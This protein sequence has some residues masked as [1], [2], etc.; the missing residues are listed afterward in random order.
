MLVN[1]NNSRQDPHPVFAVPPMTGC[2]FGSRTVIYGPNGTGKTTLVRELQ[3]HSEHDVAQLGPQWDTRQSSLFVFNERFVKDNLLQF[4]EEGKA[5]ASI[6]IGKASVKNKKRKN[7]IFEEQRELNAQRKQRT[8][9]VEQND[10]VAVETAAK[11]EVIERL[12]KYDSK[13]YQSA[14]YKRG[15]KFREKL[16]L[17]TKASLTDVEYADCVNVAQAPSLGQIV[18]IPKFPK[19][20]PANERLDSIN[21]LLKVQLGDPTEIKFSDLEGFGYW[22]EAGIKFSEKTGGLCPFCAQG[23]DFGRLESMVQAYVNDR[24]TNL[25][26]ELK[27]HQEWMARYVDQIAEYGK[28]L[29]QLPVYDLDVIQEIKSINE[30]L[31][32]ELS[33]LSSSIY[34]VIDAIECKIADLDKVSHLRVVALPSEVNSPMTD[35]DECIS[36]YNQAVEGLA[37]SRAEAVRKLEGSILS[38]FSK[39]YTAA[40]SKSQ[41]LNLEIDRID[42]RLEDLETELAS[43]LASESSTLD[44]ALEINRGI[45]TIFGRNEFEIHPSSDGQEYLL[46]RSDGPATHLS[47]GEK[48]VVCLLY[49]LAS[50]NAD[51]VDLSDSVILIDD[52]VTGLDRNNHRAL[53]DYVVS[54]SDQWQQLII[55]THD[56]GL[57]SNF[58]N[59]FGLESKTQ[60]YG[61]P[62]G[63]ILERSW[64]EDV[65]RYLTSICLAPDYLVHNSSEYFYLFDLCVRAALG[66]IPERSLGVIGNSGRRFLESFASYHLPRN[67]NFTDSIFRMWDRVDWER[68]IGR[69]KKL[70]LPNDQISSSTRHIAST[71]IRKFHASSHNES[72]TPMQQLTSPLTP[73]DFVRLLFFVSVVDYSHFSELSLLIDGDSKQR[74]KQLLAESGKFLGEVK[75]CANGA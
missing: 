14:V 29:R 44:M 48:Q 56:F 36:Q 15:K 21:K 52:P 32:P 38:E 74:L 13:Y 57:F 42:G 19:I 8:K 54:K 64:G 51:N 31:E 2:S 1:V 30:R 40:Q 33:R 55:A 4:V 68:R 72:V 27:E 17:S 28:E 6:A 23:M 69:G 3:R 47:E 66:E 50:L 9:L 26:Q 53:F 60:R 39:R 65:S 16:A 71:L 41:E 62:V 58:I 10:P 70:K 24:R 35:L 12:E 7:E 75:K 11:N 37:D 63:L 20:E 5:A 67:S 73:E 25:R 49:F 22:A 59:E 43:I 34:E 61:D 46:K 45:A 18:E